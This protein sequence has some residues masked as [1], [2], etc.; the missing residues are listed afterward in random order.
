MPA[1]LISSSPSGRGDA[2][3]A[4]AALSSSSSVPGTVP[5][6]RAAAAGSNPDRPVPGS[7]DPAQSV[8][9]GP[10]VVDASTTHVPGRSRAGLWMGL[11]AVIL[12]G[13]ALIAVL[14]TR[15][16]AAEPPGG[17]TG[18]SDQ[19][20]AVPGSAL[21][22]PLDGGV[23]L[24]I[25]A[26]SAMPTAPDATVAAPAHPDMVR[27][28]G[29]TFKM[30]IDPAKAKKIPQAEAQHDVTVA[31][32]Y[33]DRTE[34]TRAGLRLAGGTPPSGGDDI[35]ATMVPWSAASS[36]C[37]ALGKRLPTAAEWELAARSAPLD[38]KKSSLLHEHRGGPAR[39]GSH[40]GDCTPDGVC[41]LLGNVM[42]W[43]A[44]AWPGRTGFMVVRGASFNVGADAG[45][46]AT[47]QARLPF[48]ADAGDK[49]IGFRCAADAP[50]TP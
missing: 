11:T 13:G 38:P 36:A 46:Y 27:F 34:M 2:L 50:P 35:P 16:K 12:A 3:A 29:G 19:R 39:A 4:T 32:F 28:P 49:E 26:G 44:D 25:D 1:H 47:V 24:A 21:H 7:F 23:A 41:D 40:A 14:A 8:T 45:W 22:K 20:D 48:A 15:G 9:P 10:V 42:E 33:L 17:G 37:Q 6:S 30:G 5:G 31:P 43:T 18:R